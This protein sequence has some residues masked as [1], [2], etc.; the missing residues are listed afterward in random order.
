MNLEI[1][2]L[3]ASAFKDLSC[4]GNKL[5]QQMLFV[6]GGLTQGNFLV[7]NKFLPI[8]LTDCRQKLNGNMLPEEVR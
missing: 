8:H 4:C 2:I 7:N 5:E 6:T 3:F 1:K